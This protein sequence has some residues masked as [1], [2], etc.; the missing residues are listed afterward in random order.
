MAKKFGF[1]KKSKNASARKVEKVLQEQTDFYEEGVEL[2]ELGERWI[3]SDIKKTLNFYYQAVTTY[4]AGLQCTVNQSDKTSYNIAYNRLTLLLKL[5]SEYKHVNGDTDI[6]V[7]VV[8]LAPDLLSMLFPENMVCQLLSQFDELMVQS[9]SNGLATWDLYYNYL[10][11]IL[12]F[13]NTRDSYM[14]DVTGAEIVQLSDKFS[15]IFKKLIDYHVEFFDSI[16]PNIL[17]EEE[18]TRQELLEYPNLEKDEFL[19]SS[20]FDVNTGEGIRLANNNTPIS[21]DSNAN[22][23]KQSQNMTE[24]VES[25]SSMSWESYF[26]TLTV[27]NTFVNEI[28]ELIISHNS[29]ES[30]AGGSQLTITGNDFQKNYII[31]SMNK[32]HSQIIGL[33]ETSR[34][35]L[36]QPF[37]EQA[38]ATDSTKELTL[39]LRYTDYLTHYSEYSYLWN[40]L[41]EVDP[42]TC[43]SPDYL[44][45]EIDFLRLV[46]NLDNVATFFS[47]EDRWSMV[48]KLDKFLVR[49]IQLVSKEKSNI[50]IGLIKDR[51]NELSPL[52]TTLSRL[53][54]RR[55]EN[56][57]NRLSLQKQK[58]ESLQASL[59]VSQ[60][61]QQKQMESAEKTITVLQKNVVMLCTNAI[62]VAKQSCGVREYINDKLVRNSVY[63][64][65]TELQA[66][67]SF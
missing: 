31:N 16:Q 25:S 37:V 39:S 23:N 43:D 33:F 54:I 63:Q 50:A 20:S 49:A 10:T 44:L 18:K 35:S 55:S 17:S 42:Q 22:T 28:L 52:T 41:N 65:A 3:L 1:P 34:A 66:S 56:E 46:C 53:Y 8:G 11:A 40:K 5:Q 15:Y 14:A 51:D 12:L 58:Y 9:E 59:Q 27:A 21:N 61:E 2:E 19:K 32:L 29:T 24:F 48:T 67:I 62:N 4:N 57:L 30:H 38:P 26:D 45:N 36:Q 60:E 6:L 64:E 47:A 13:L 7:Y